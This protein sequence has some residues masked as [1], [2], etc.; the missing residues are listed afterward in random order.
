LR[1]SRDAT[2]RNGRQIALACW[3]GVVI[4]D[5]ASGQEL[6]GMSRLSDHI[7][8]LAWSPDGQR[9]ACGTLAGQIVIRDSRR[10]YEMDLATPVTAP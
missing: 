9:I 8:S 10:S 1:R 6:Q 5:A 4:M 2:V 3:K 7:R